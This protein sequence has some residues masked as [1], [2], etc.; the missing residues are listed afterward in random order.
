MVE[1]KKFALTLT[2]SEA[3]TLVNVWLKATRGSRPLLM[4]GEPGV[5]ELDK[6]IAKE[7]TL[8]VLE[9]PANPQPAQNEKSLSH[10][11]G[12]QQ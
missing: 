4:P 3:R 11:Q 7:L 5:K 10:N 1:E 2:H 9:I 12:G 6:L 8:K